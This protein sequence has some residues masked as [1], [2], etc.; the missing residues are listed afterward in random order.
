M[1]DNSNWT[2][3][4]RQN[5]VN[6][7]FCPTIKGNYGVLPGFTAQPIQQCGNNSNEPC[8]FDSSSLEDAINTCNLRYDICSTFSYDENT[9]QMQIISPNDVPLA[10]SGINIYIRQ[11]DLST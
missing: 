5:L 2:F 8:T 4:Q 1:P 9:G 3:N 7:K 10:A 11:T 6:P